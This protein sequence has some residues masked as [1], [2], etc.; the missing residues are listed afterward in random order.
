MGEKRGWDKFALE[1]EEWDTRGVRLASDSRKNRAGL[2]WASVTRF[3]Q[4]REMETG[5]AV[6]TW[7]LDVNVDS[8]YLSSKRE[9]SE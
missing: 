3:S 4:K 1:L 5:I 9:I 2:G 6:L 7:H 8:G